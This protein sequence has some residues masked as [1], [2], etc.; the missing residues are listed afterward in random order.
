ML[1][2]TVGLCDFTCCQRN[3]RFGNKIVPCDRGIAREI[4]QTLIASKVESLY[5]IEKFVL[6]R[7]HFCCTKFWTRVPSC[8]SPNQIETLASLKQQLKWGSLDCTDEQNPW[9]DREGISILMYAIGL[10]NVVLVNEILKLYE[11]KRAQLLAWR[12]PQDGVPE[13]G[14]RKLDLFFI[15]QLI[16]TQK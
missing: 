7:T 8:S 6:A 10:D 11:N 9:L 4:L 3:H 16:Q 5:N 2:L 15:A 12:V 14:V 1:K 13:V